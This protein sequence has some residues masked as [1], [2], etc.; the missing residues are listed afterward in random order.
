MI[1]ANLEIKREQAGELRLLAT[2]ITSGDQ[3]DAVE[4]KQIDQDKL[5]RIIA[6]N[7]DQVKVISPE[8]LRDEVAR[9][10]AGVSK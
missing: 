6:K 2:S 3:F 1:D 7:C 10:L 8:I 9:L 5:A 4:I